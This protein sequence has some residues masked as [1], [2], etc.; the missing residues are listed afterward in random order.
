VLRPH[1]LRENSAYR[2]QMSRRR[3]LVTTRGSAYAIGLR[4]EFLMH[5]CLLMNY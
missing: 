2:E 3:W 1:G 5:D 4:H